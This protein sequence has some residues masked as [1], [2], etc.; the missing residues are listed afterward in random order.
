MT[1]S[2]FSWSR[3]LK[4]GKTKRGGGWG[5]SLIWGENAP[6]NHQISHVQPKGSSKKSYFLVPPP[7]LVAR[8]L[9]KRTFFAASQRICS[10]FHITSYV[11]NIFSVTIY[12]L[13]HFAVLILDREAVRAVYQFQIYFLKYSKNFADD[14]LSVIDYIF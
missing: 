6:E 14:I 9:K 2:S 1:H 10:L 5:K 7:F 4:R 12:F 8:P 3:R 11:H 13:L